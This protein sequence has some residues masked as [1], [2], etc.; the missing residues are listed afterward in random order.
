MG[1]LITLGVAWGVMRNKVVVLGTSQKTTAAS[2]F[3]TQEQFHQCQLSSQ[4]RAGH[5]EATLRAIKEL[6]VDS[7]EDRKG[8]HEYFEANQRDLIERITRV[9]AMINGKMA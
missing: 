8:M 4:N 7:K 5:V 1:A 2:L 3:V 9:E 6:L